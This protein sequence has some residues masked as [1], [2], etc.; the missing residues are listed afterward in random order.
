MAA[1]R[2]NLPPR[3]LP[4]RCYQ[5]GLQRKYDQ[6]IIR[7]LLLVDGVDVVCK[8]LLRVGLWV[9][10]GKVCCVEKATQRPMANDLTV[11]QVVIDPA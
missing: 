6:L 8:V 7:R 11:D 1:V 2:N 9:A 5:G 3:K 10:A 4:I